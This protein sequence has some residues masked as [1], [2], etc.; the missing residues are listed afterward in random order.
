M[1]AENKKYCIIQNNE[2]IEIE[3]VSVLN[4]TEFSIEMVELLKQ[5]ENHCVSI[6][7]FPQPDGLK[8][9]AAIA[10]DSI[11]RIFVLSHFLLNL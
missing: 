8:F 6:F 1:V 11:H 7:A 2:S 10:N 9:F 3:S 4:Y 5:N